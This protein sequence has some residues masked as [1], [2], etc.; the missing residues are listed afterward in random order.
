MLPNFHS[1]CWWS[2]T[3][4]NSWWTVHS[5]NSCVF[6]LSVSSSS[7]VSNVEVHAL[8][9]A[10]RISLRQGSRERVWQILTRRDTEHFQ[11]S[12]LYWLLEPQETYVNVSI[13]LQSL[14]SRRAFCCAAVAT[15]VN[16]AFHS[17]MAIAQHCSDS[18]RM[19]W[20]ATT[21]CYGALH[22]APM[23]GQTRSPHDCHSRSELARSN[24]SIVVGVAEH[25]QNS[26]QGLWFK[27]DCSNW[28]HPQV[29]SN[30]F[31]FFK[32]FCRGTFSSFVQE[33]AQQ[34][35]SLGGPET[36]S[37]HASWPVQRG[38]LCIQR[39][40]FCQQQK[41]FRLRTLGHKSYNWRWILQSQISKQNCNV[42]RF[43]LLLGSATV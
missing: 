16:L 3:H 19:S 6:L 37:L 30:T 38:L 15:H 40:R 28:S 8:E 43:G 34:M 2:A 35:T 26:R 22:R 5:W 42:P 27:H 7:T 4:S 1:H 9:A 24:V 20:L 41:F 33:I 18:E 31:E 10:I 36:G 17:V 12:F 39:F 23:L 32:V 13:F 25:L 14:A 21:Q 11:R 29:A